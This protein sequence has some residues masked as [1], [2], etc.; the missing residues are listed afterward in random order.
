LFFFLLKIF[1]SIFFRLNESALQE[2]VLPKTEIKD[3][4]KTDFSTIFY[5]NYTPVNLHT[6]S[7]GLAV[8]SPI[9]NNLNQ[10]NIK[11]ERR[12]EDDQSDLM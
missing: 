9:E 11:N 7:E 5:H 1:I 8:T 10:N 6:D 12:N 3:E 2:S 4:F